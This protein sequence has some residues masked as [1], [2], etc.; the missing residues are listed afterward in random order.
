MKTTS[1]NNGEKHPTCGNKIYW[2]IILC[3]GVSYG[4]FV[5]MYLILPQNPL[6][7][8]EAHHSVYSLMIAKSIMRF[9]INDFARFTNTQIY[10]P[11]LHSWISSF[12]LILGG[13]SYSSV[14]FASLVTGFGSLILIAVIGKKLVKPGGEAIG[15]LS[16]CLMLLCPILLYFSSAVFLENQGLFFSLGIIGFQFS[17]WKKQKNCYF[18]A[19][20]IL[21]SLLYLT[22][23]IYALFMGLTLVI[24]WLSFI[25]LPSPQFKKQDLLKII[26]WVGIGFLSIWGIWMLIPPTAN[27]F[28]ILLYR[29]KD[30]GSWNPLNFSQ[31]DNRLF[32]LRALLYA[33][34]FS[35]GIYLMYLGGLIF[36][37]ANFRQP[38]FRFLTIFFLVNTIPM[39]FI[40]NSQERFIYIST[41]C[42]FLLTA[43]FMYWAWTKLKGTWRWSAIII[44]TILVAGDLPKMPGYIRHIGNMGGL[45]FRVKNKFNFTTL[46]GLSTYPHWLRFPKSPFN[47]K[48]WE[49]IHT[50]NTEAILKFVWD[51]TDPRGAIC[52][53]FYIVTLSP[54]LWTWHSIIKQRPIVTR[55]HS[56]AYYFITLQVDNDSPYSTLW[57]KNL[58]ESSRKWEYFIV[59]L[60]KRNLM[61]LFREVY[62]PDSGL[63]AKIYIKKAPVTE[64][65]WRDIHYP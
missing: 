13:F 39:S 19:S 47:P 58:I 52:A 64:Q 38:K 14:R 56:N 34:T 15:L 51:N 45:S 61:S 48:A 49:K 40:V 33:Y 2:L 10:W 1:Q 54:H 26:L 55:W 16:A 23:Y 30:T 59:D 29:I 7:W 8:D 9:N 65:V 43:A 63:G 44:L 18:F 5:Y 37:L 46:F 31:L 17:G 62:F 4:I 25:P 22:K 32:Y 35:I 24:F 36:G 11:F 42:L 27:K 20:G 28:N 60:E 50:R 3:L 21:L 6:S 41:P 53:P 12:F 57:N